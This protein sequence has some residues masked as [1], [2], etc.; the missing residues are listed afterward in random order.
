[1][2]KDW[3]AVATAIKQRMAEL[4]CKQIGI[5]QSSGLAKR[6]VGEIQNNTRQRRRSRRTLEGISQALDWHPGH[7]AAVLEG[8][9]PPKL[10]EPF[11]RSTNDIVGRLDAIERRLTEIA[12]QARGVKTVEARLSS[13]SKEPLE[14][15]SSRRRADVSP[16]PKPGR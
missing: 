16:T 5:I 6:T 12:D 4:E 14:R 3:T 1:V 9:R 7:L 2:K 13:L 11:V 10:G 8:R 15:S